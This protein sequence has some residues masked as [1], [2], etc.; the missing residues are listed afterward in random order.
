MNINQVQKKLF[1]WGMGQANNAD[2]GK[3]KLKNHPQYENFAQL[4]QA[5]LGQVFGTVLEIGAGA[6][7]NFSYYPKDIKWLGIEPN[8]FMFYHL[9]KEAEKQGIKSIKLTK[10]YAE[11]LP[12]ANESID[13]VVSTHVLCS[14]N[15]VEESL[16]E[17]Y[18]VLKPDS[19]FI[20][21]EH[22]RADDGTINFNLQKIIEPIWVTMFDNCHLQRE[23][24]KLLPNVGFRNIEYSYFQLSI[25]IVSPH[26]SGIAFK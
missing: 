21:L 5:L 13:T 8:N 7:A 22:I 23:P 3:I 12:F 26:V 18:R 15:N 2:I 16:K 1:A 10:G 17:I 14:V 20:F 19:Q 24:E 9:E 4:K 25:P 11:A 6:G